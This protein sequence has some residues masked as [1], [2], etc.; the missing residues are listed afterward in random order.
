[1]VQRAVIDPI[2]V[3]FIW[4]LLGPTNIPAQFKN[5]MRRPSSVLV[6]NVPAK[7][8]CN[9]GR[10]Q[11]LHCGG[12]TERNGK[13]RCS[14]HMVVQLIV[15]GSLPAFT[16]SSGHKDCGLSRT[17]RILCAHGIISLDIELSVILFSGNVVGQIV[18]LGFNGNLWLSSLMNT[19]CKMALRV[20]VEARVRV[21]SFRNGGLGITSF[22]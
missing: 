12:D 7:N 22:S 14:S 2:L 5:R 21:H 11:S 8:R 3:A 17:M 20:R 19:H 15:I 18:S 4:T 9:A 10:Q 6:S 13:V 16:F 1:M